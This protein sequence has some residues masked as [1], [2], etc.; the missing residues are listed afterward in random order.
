MQYLWA[1]SAA[2]I[3][4]ET[5]FTVFD[6]S[7]AQLYNRA[8]SG[9]FS[10]SLPVLIIQI[11]KTFGQ[12]SSPFKV[13][14]A[15]ENSA[16]PRHSFDIALP[17]ILTYLAKNNCFYMNSFVHACTYAV[18]REIYH[19]ESNS[20]R[21]ETAAAV[22]HQWSHSAPASGRAGQRSTNENTYMHMNEVDAWS[23]QA[24]TVCLIA[25]PGS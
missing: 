8:H 23:N 3:A 14:L 10:Y 12:E 18:K 13:K 20:P 19:L 11:D 16:S 5:S 6:A 4:H 17:Q 25:Y 24:Q 1:Q 21:G 15:V 9:F 2:A 7:D 22:C